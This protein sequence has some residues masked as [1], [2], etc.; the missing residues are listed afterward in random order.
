MSFA[1]KLIE[2]IQFIVTAPPAYGWY[3][4]LMLAITAGVTVLFVKKFRTCDDISFRRVV[5][6]CWIVILALE[7]FK[8][9]IYSVYITDGQIAFAYQWWT[10]PFQFCS[11]PLY[12][13]PFLAFLP[14]G[15]VYNA[16]MMFTATFCFFG[17]FVVMLYPGDVFTYYIGINIQ[18]MVHHGMQVVMGILCALRLM[19][20]KKYT[21]WN[22]LGGSIVF[23]SMSAIALVL[24]EI[25]YDR[26]NLFYISSHHTSTLPILSSIYPLV[27]YPVFL[28]IY[29]IGFMLAAQ[30]IYWSIL[31]ITKLVCHIKRGGK[32]ETLS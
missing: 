26:V 22:F 20:Q 27:P 25:W 24:N 19:D 30:I 18:T 10:F 6:I 13:L 16:L 14:K 29:L 9:F 17:G 32:G 3:H 5:L 8:Q 15:K 12:I 31:G 23:A 7:L 2:L 28:L 1:I 21:M 11:S 4:L